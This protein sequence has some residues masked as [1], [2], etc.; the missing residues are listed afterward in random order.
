MF[1]SSLSKYGSRSVQH[2]HLEEGWCQA[3]PGQHGD[4][5]G[6]HGDGLH[7]IFEERMLVIKVRRGNNLVPSSPDM[8][9]EHWTPVTVTAS[10]G[11]TWRMLCCSQ[12]L[13]A[14]R[15]SRTPSRG[16]SRPSLR[17]WSGR[18]SMG[19]RRGQP[20]WLKGKPLRGNALAL[21][22]LICKIMKLLF[23]V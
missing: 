4:G 15:S 14:S 5:L 1:S 21:R 20:N 11:A 2:D 12:C 7:S 23:I 8:N 13:S 22:G 16:S 17:W 3:T 9:I 6:Q 19:W 10:F 18:W